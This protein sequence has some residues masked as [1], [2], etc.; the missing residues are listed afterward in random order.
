MRI[1]LINPKY[2]YITPHPL[3]HAFLDKVAGPLLAKLASLPL[4]TIAGATPPEIE[5]EYMDENF[6]DEIN[7]DQEVD[8]V[9]LT[10]MTSQATRAYEIADEY[11]Q[12]GRPVVMGGIHAS[13]LPDEAKQHADTVIVGEAEET[14]PLFIADFQ[15]GK[16]GDFYHGAIADLEKAPMPRYDLLGRFDYSDAPQVLVPAQ[17]SRGCAR[18]CS[19]CSVTPMYGFG[20]RTKTVGH[21]VS[22]VETFLMNFLAVDNM[23]MRLNDANLFL[24]RDASVE[25]LKAL[26]PM[27][28]RWHTHAD[29]SVGRDG[30]LLDLLAESGCVSVGIGLESLDADV[31]QDFSPWKKAQLQTLTTSIRAIQSRGIFVGGNLIMGLKPYREDYLKLVR[32]FVEENKI[33]CQFTVA[34]PYPGTKFYEELKGQGRLRAGM[35]WRYYNTANVVFDAAMDPEKILEDLFWLYQETMIKHRSFSEKWIAAQATYEPE[36]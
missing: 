19:F 33:L 9:G 34:T 18:N 2:D 6:S 3:L 28:L 29:I 21:F 10:F 27:N 4:L 12:R 7:Y 20:C 14:W 30:P 31:L 5:V 25:L 24:N 23:A 11:R 15:R 32:D 26:I 8:L 36:G 17:F 22:E 16:A 13:V 1:V 35:D